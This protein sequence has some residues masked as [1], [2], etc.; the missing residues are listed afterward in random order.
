MGVLVCGAVFAEEWPMERGGPSSS[1]LAASAL[2]DDLHV[3]WKYSV[4]DAAFEATPV[5]NGDTLYVGDDHGTFH[6]LEIK[7]GDPVWTRPLEDTGFLCGAAVTSTALFAGD[8]DGTFWCLA[9]NDG[10]V[11]WSV[12]LEAECYAGP[13][14]HNGAVLVTNEAGVLTSLRQSDGAE[15]WKYEIEAPLRCAPTVVAGRALLAGCDQKLHMVNAESGTA[16]GT[17]EIDSQTGSTPAALG[18][19]VFFGTEAGT[20]YAIDVDQPEPAVAWTYRDPLRGQSIRCAAA[21]DERLV[22]YGSHGKS[23]YA[24]DPQTGE[25]KWDF[26]T[27]SRVEAG[28]VIAGDRVVVATA[29]GR[30]YLLD[31]ADGSEVGQYD[32]GGGF[33]ASQCVVDGRVL[34]GNTDGTLY[35]FGDR[36]HV[37]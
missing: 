19:R 3:L 36:E 13:I 32:A 20:L 6:A 31:V 33:L 11:Q 7:S 14:L 9:R 1:G 37:E 10:T 2:A 4:D 12:A 26:A 28:P 5:V 29:K 25:R 34:I 8:Y 17:L 15:N 24:L 16:V 21:V 27:K 35:C 22:V 23:V 18:G 30:L